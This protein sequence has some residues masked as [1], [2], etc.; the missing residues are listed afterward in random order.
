M[1]AES[2]AIVSLDGTG[3]LDAPYRTGTLDT[4]FW[5]YTSITL[6]ESREEEGGPGGVTDCN[7]HNHLYTP[8]VDFTFLIAAGGSVGILVTMWI[9]YR[10]YH[11]LFLIYCRNLTRQC[12]DG[13][14]PSIPDTVYVID[15]CLE[16]RIRGSG[17]GVPGMAGVLARM[18]TYRKGESPPPPNDSPPPYHVAITM[19]EVP[20]IVVSEPVVI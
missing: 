11:L 4:P 17:S 16:G 5:N 14:T 8:R 3:G 7:E 20:D 9:L 6:A 13:D 15:S 19:G 18:Q 10:A 12:L 2:L 1:G